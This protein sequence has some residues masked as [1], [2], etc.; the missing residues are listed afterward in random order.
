MIKRTLLV[1]GM[2]Y[3]SLVGLA[4]K[5]GQVT[6][7][8]KDALS[9]Q[10]L[11]SA[12]VSLGLLEENKEVKKVSSDGKGFFSFKNLQDGLYRVSIEYVGYNTFIKDSILISGNQKSLSLS[13]LFLQLQNQRPAG[14]MFWLLIAPIFRF[15]F[16]A[17]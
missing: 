16:R 17:L 14:P 6:G 11:P 5:S 2:I 9:K 4:Q 13:A 10:P 15:V 1:I 3:F 12:T 7:T 8:V